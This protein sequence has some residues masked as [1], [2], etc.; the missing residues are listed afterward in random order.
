MLADFG[1][2]TCWNK[3]NFLP[4]HYQNL[5]IMAKTGSKHGGN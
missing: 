2:R 3:N 1:R 4:L 5:P